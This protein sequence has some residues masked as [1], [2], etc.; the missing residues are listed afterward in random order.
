[1]LGP[2]SGCAKTSGLAWF[3]GYSNSVCAITLVLL[4]AL[5]GLGAATFE[6]SRFWPLCASS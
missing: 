4:V 2:V 3:L 5:S 6:V 1:M